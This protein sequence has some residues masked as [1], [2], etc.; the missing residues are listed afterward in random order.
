MPASSIVGMSGASGERCLPLTPSARNFP[1]FTCGK[2]VAVSVIIIW[3][4]PPRRSLIASGLLLYGTCSSW[5]PAICWNN[6]PATRDDELPLP[7]DT[8]PG[9]LFAYATNSITVFVGT[10]GLTTMIWPPRPSAVTGAK[11]LTG[12]YGSF[13]NRCSFADCVVL[14]VM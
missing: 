14:V 8:A 4:W 3:I 6:S 13:L 5:T 7:N 10:V 12:S 9:L 2:P 11:S 1:A